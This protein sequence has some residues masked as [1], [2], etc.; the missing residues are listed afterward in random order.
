MDEENSTHDDQAPP[1]TAPENFNIQ[2]KGF[3][4][5]ER[6][7]AI[8]TVVG[9]L[10]RAFSTKLDLSELDG[11]TVA[12]NYSEALAE[13][14]RGLETR[15]TLAPTNSH[16]VGVAMTPSVIRDGCLKSHIVFNGHNLLPLLD[17]K[18]EEGRNQAIH[19]IAHECAHVEV[20]KKFDSCFPN[21]MLRQQQPILERLQW[22]TI[23]SV[24]DEYAVTALSSAWG[25]TQTE[26]YEATFINDLATLDDRTNKLIRQYRMSGTVDQV[27]EEVYDCCGTVLKFAAYHLGNLQGLGIDW[28]A[29]EKTESHLR[30]HWFLPYFERLSDACQAVAEGYGE[31][32]DSSTFKLISDISDDLVSR[33]GLKITLTGT[34]QVHVHI[35]WTEATDPSRFL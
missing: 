34:A 26:A 3:H 27:L 18:D 4:D 6:A 10:V 13:L 7:T 19:I 25:A 32:G 23:F 28:R 21:V 20:T 11:V 9:K 12:L 35:R 14:D 22:N 2:V 15:K 17:D 16:V 24:W 8:G 33:A 5:T 1:S 31:W 30:D 29:L